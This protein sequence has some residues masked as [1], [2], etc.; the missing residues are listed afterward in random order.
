MT[1]LFSLVEGIS[2]NSDKTHISMLHFCDNLD[3]ATLLD[4]ILWLKS[5]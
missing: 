4:E 3:R 2:T 1:N 5:E